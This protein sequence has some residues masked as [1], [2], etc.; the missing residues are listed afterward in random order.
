MK[1]HVKK[2]LLGL[3]ICVFL[4]P[5]ASFAGSCST[6]YPVVLAHGM[7]ASAS[8]LGIVDYWWNIDNAL[9]NNGAK[10]YK[11]SVNGMDSTTAKAA[12]FKT[13]FLQILAAT[14][15]AKA[16][17]IGHS[18][19]CLYTRYAISNLGLSTKV[20]T[21][22]GMCGPNRGSYI[23]N[24]VC[25]NTPSYIR[26]V[27]AGSLNFVYA[28]IFGDTN[29]NSLQNGYDLCTDYVTNTFNPQTPNMSG[30]YY[31]SWAAKG[32]ISVPDIILEPTWAILCVS[33][34]ANDG[35]VAESSAKWG[36]Y[37]GCQSA[38][39]Y[40]VGCDHLNMVDQLF[41]ITPG[42]DAPSFYVSVVNDLK[43]K[44]Y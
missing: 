38:A 4:F 44:G 36:T 41:G 19:G 29:P 33:D 30:V 14:G 7:G 40:S 13:Q 21:W 20:A 28:F 5:A 34:G 15:A 8:I 1:R 42:F 35:L 18:H 10:V 12:S 11:T 27:L 22:T 26:S 39:W 37:K 32:K 31:Q 6:K 16:N 9:A 3:L 24:L 25:Y 43:N 23:A 2:I 17:I